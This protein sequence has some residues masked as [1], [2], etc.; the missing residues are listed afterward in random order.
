MRKTL[1]N[2]VFLLAVVLATVNQILEKGFGIFIPLIHSYLDDLLCFPIVLTLGLAAYRFF[3]PN[4]RLTTWHMLPVLLVYSV[5]FEI[6]LP[7]VTANATAD[8]VDVVM[9]T[10]GLTVFGYFINDSDAVG[11][12]LNQ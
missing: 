7:S 10:I 4:Y 2:P 12:E 5:Y 3:W 11:L 9:Y 6:Y 8:I 1:S